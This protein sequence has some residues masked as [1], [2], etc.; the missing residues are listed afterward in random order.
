MIL[1][2]FLTSLLF[3]V[4]LTVHYCWIKPRKMIKFY[5]NQ[6]KNMKWRYK[7]IPY[8]LFYNRYTEPLHEG[9]KL[10]DPM[11]LYKN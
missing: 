7:V 10:G 2:I 11:I 5:E 4:L 9:K 1:E 3:L 8:K 6:L